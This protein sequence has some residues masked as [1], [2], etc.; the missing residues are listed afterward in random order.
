MLGRGSGAGSVKIIFQARQ[1]FIVR[2]ALPA[3]G[4]SVNLTLPSM[5][6]SAVIDGVRISSSESSGPEIE[7]GRDR[8]APLFEKTERRRGRITCPDLTVGVPG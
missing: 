1:R 7:P 6:Q 3:R 5:Q 2:M 8:R 4:S